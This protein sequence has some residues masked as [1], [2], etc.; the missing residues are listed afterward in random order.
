MSTKL[1]LFCVAMYILGQALTLFWITV[2]SLK[3]KCRIANKEF[4]WK[5]WWKC[6]WNIVFGNMIFGLILILGLKELITWKPE[7]L[8]FVKWLF[9]L[10]GAFGTS[11]AQEKWGQFRKTLNN[12]L[13]MKAN[14][15]D[16]VT[17]GSN[18]VEET[19]SK[20]KNA[21]VDIETSK[22]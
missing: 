13:D 3:E 2:P 6:D 14:L 20:G 4:S 17:G 1:Y 18:T 12:L 21:G 9:A 8:D 19:V 16:A 10:L 11:I 7:I 15:S 5:D 22:K